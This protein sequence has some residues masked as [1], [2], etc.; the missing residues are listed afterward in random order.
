MTSARI[1]PDPRQTIEQARRLADDL[2]RLLLNGNR[3]TA[4]DLYNAPT[5]DCWAHTTAASPALI[6]V[7]S[8]HPL[9]ADG[10]I[11]VTS[12]LFALGPSA[13]QPWARTWSRWY[14]LGD[15]AAPAQ[16]P[17]NSNRRWPL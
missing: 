10:R 1:G 13:S 14:K 15:P 11:A 6:G 7:L 12:N 3:P 8:G 4:S 16:S 5:I 17:S 9:I 2:E